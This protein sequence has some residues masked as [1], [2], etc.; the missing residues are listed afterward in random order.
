MTIVIKE[1]GEEDNKVCVIV[2]CRSSECFS[3]SQ[4]LLQA[5]K[6]VNENNRKDELHHLKSK[7]EEISRLNS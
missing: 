7:N 2:D 5:I 3:V 6:T 1:G 4:C